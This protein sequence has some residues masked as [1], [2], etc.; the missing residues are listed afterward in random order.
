M[1]RVTWADLDP[2]F[3]RLRRE[4][5]LDGAGGGVEASA[6]RLLE[7]SRIFAA[8]DNASER[9][10]GIETLT[11]ETMEVSGVWGGRGLI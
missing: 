3:P 6:E 9:H 1:L 5:S 11:K 4:K 7:I 8:Q 2:L 10:A